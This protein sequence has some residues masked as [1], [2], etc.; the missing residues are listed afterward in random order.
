LNLPIH[1]YPDFLIALFWFLGFQLSNAPQSE[2]QNRCQEIRSRPQKGNFLAERSTSTSKL[3]F[4]WS[5]VRSAF[6]LLKDQEAEQ[7]MTKANKKTNSPPHTPPQFLFGFKDR[8][9]RV[10]IQP[11]YEMVGEFDRG[12]AH[13]KAKKDGK[14]GVI[15][16]SG[17]CV[18]EPQFELIGKVF[19]KHFTYR[20]ASHWGLAD[21]KGN[22]VAKPEF[23]EIVSVGRTVFTVRK[24]KEFKILDFKLKEIMG[25]FDKVF[26]WNDGFAVAVGGKTSGIIGENGKW[27]VPPSEDAVY[28][29]SDGLAAFDKDGASGYYDLSGRIAIQPQ[30][31]SAFDFS[32]GLAR[33]Q[34][35]GKYGYIDRNGKIVI[36]CKWE[37]P[38]RINFSGNTEEMTQ[39]R[40]GYAKAAKEGDVLLQCGYLDKAGKW[41]DPDSLPQNPRD[42][43]ELVS[44]RAESIEW[45]RQQEGIELGDAFEAKLARYKEKLSGALKKD[46]AA[47][48]QV[49]KEIVSHSFDKKTSW[50]RM[51][52]S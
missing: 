9:D 13:A 19:E 44:F 40:A 6:K 33:V 27:L 38:V 11:M 4:C 10:R 39:F 36:P 47:A 34:M 30:F 35:N 42:D 43:R 14:W 18:C 2:E 17:Q 50:L 15:S 49:V 21:L 25:G 22:E 23:D 32:E 37:D 29:F 46:E 52:I 48:I 26:N 41:H 12:Q 8:A 3:L 16:T 1:C 20:V 45:Q 7:S 24:A 5:L 28:D 51:T 31:Q